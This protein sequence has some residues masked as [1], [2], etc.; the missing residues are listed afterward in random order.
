MFTLSLVEEKVMRA[1][2][3]TEKRI[4][5]HITLRIASQVVSVPVEAAP[6][7]G[8]GLVE[9]FFSTPDGYG[10]RVDSRS[11]DAKQREAVERASVEAAKV[12]SRKFLN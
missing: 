6:L 10:I 9:G 3:N 7:E 8:T 11:S 4:V 5:G 1:S 12:L 2:E